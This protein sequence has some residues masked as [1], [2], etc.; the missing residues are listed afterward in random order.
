MWTVLVLWPLG[1]YAQG[2]SP[3]GLPV[4][5][6]DGVK[7]GQVLDVTVIGGNIEQIRI[8]TSS[9]LGFGERSVAIPTPAFEIKGDMILIP[10][11]SSADIE[12]LPTEPAEHHLPRVPKEQTKIR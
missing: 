10:D 9:T 3:V 7:V 12:A 8:S 4:F 2:G 1:C 11:L 5:A 6:G